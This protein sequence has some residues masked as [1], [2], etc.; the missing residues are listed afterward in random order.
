MDVTDIY[1]VA[2]Q[3]K[4]SKNAVVRISRGETVH[5]NGN[6]ISPKTSMVAVF[7]QDS[8]T[9]MIGVLLE[10]KKERVMGVSLQTKL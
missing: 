2:M 6:T 10:V 1:I 4:V 3:R 7:C 9:E 8:G 5:T